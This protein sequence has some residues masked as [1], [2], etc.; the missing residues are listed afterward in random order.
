M[1]QRI[2]A[3]F[4]GLTGT[5][6]LDPQGLRSNIAVDLMELKSFGLKKAGVWRAESQPRISFPVLDQISS[7]DNFEAGP[8]SNRTFRVII[9]IVSEAISNFMQANRMH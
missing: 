1:R 9:A 4:D 8:I 3:V 7:S 2:Q 5:V 6:E